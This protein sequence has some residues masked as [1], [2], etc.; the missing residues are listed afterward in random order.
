M[1]ELTNVELKAVAGGYK[2]SC[3]PKPRCE[4][5]KVVVC[6]PKPVC[7]TRRDCGPVAEA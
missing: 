7:R 6:R 5:R 2:R 3:Q 4:P 1:R